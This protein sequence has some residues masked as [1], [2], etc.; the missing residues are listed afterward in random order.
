MK[1][2]LAMFV[3]VAAGVAALPVSLHFEG[4][5]GTAEPFLVAFP[6]VV[7]LAFGGA[8]FAYRRRASVLVALNTLAGVV[9]LL[10]WIA[11]VMY[12]GD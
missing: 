8:F 6:L 10:G 2:P 4:N 11:L 1:L 12:P 9:A 3:L 5:E 7:L